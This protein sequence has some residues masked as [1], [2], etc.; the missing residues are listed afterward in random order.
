ME[1][2][3]K[4]KDKPT[5]VKVQYP[6]LD[7]KNL[8]E[9]QKA[10]GDEVVFTAAKGAIVISLQAFMRRHIDKGTPVADLQKEVSAWKPDVRTVVKQSAFE[11]VTSSLDKLSPEERKALLAKLQ[12][13]K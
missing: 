8:G 4:T 9:L 6:A 12:A 11:K 7:A 2:Q 5:P 13:T 3:A 10:F 1:V